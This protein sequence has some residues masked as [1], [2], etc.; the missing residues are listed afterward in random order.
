[1]SVLLTLADSGDVAMVAVIG[2]LTIWIISIVSGT[3]KESAQTRQ[4][5]ESKR[6]IAAYVAE[7]SLSAEDAERILRSDM[8]S[9][10]AQRSRTTP[11]SDAAAPAHAGAAPQRAGAV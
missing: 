2:G 9:P 6:E 4:R 5:E 1:M 7:G 3:I 10:R 8:K 11:G